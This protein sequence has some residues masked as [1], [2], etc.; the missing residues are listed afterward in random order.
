MTRGDIISMKKTI[1]KCFILFLFVASSVATTPAETNTSHHLNNIRHDPDLTFQFMQAMPKGGDIHNH[2]SGAAYAEELLQFA[3][4]DKLCLDQS[5]MTVFP[6]E[7]CQ[8]PSI[9]ALLEQPELINQT[10]DAWSMRNFD[11]SETLGAEQFFNSFS[12]FREI[13]YSHQADILALLTEKAAQHHLQYL[14]LMIHLIHKEHLPLAEQLDSQIDFQHWQQ[15]LDQLDIQSI[16][17]ILSQRLQQLEQQRK[18]LL[19]CD[20]RISDACQVTLYYQYQATRTRPL[21][22]VFTELYL[23][24]LIAAQEQNIVGVNFVG[25]EHH[26]YAIDDY[27]QHMAIFNYFKQQ[28]PQV[29]ISLHAGE[30]T[31]DITDAKHTTFHITQAINTAKA[32]RIGHGVAINQEKN[33]KQLLQQ[34]KKQNILVEISL[35]SNDAILNIRKQQ[36]QLHTYLK[37]QVPV[38]LSTDDEG[39]LRTNISQEYTR[40][41]TEHQLDYPTI[42]QLNRN[43]LTY[44]FIPGENLWSKPTCVRQLS[45]TKLTKF[46]QQFLAKNQKAA[47]QWQLEKRLQAFEQQFK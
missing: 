19:Q 28:F 47:L 44:S 30:L 14:E 36:Q 42:K 10:I 2:V 5:S 18:T 41:A 7:Q 27:Q 25:P 11:Y 24:F 1:S 37:H 33:A 46:C 40:A 23:A 9:Q 21:P 43:S 4:N 17:G 16:T 12:K 45:K 29:N 3:A 20:Q 34:M 26:T 8:G 38:T 39:V 32:Q 31:T 13:T 6:G 35:T 22:Q 15:Q